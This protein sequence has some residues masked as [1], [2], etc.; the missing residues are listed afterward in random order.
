MVKNPDALQETKKTW[1]GSLSR[2][3][4]L[5]ME[6][7]T[8]SRVLAGK[9]PWTERSL[10]GHSPQGHRESEMIEPMSMHACT[11]VIPQYFKI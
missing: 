10:V 7:A 5:E 1:V 8:S 6:M 3:D 2:E 4:S 9:I 11:H